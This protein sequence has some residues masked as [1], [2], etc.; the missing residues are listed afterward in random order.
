MWFVK[1]IAMAF[2]LNRKFRKKYNKL[3]RRD[4]LAANMLLLLAELADEGGKVVMPVDED[5]TLC[6]LQELMAA[7][8]NDPSEDY[9]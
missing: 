9:S 6:Q 7:R 2:K 8:F 1:G 3:F 5:E 4:P